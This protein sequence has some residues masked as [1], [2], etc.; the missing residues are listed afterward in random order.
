MELEDKIDVST[1]NTVFRDAIELCQHLGIDF[2]WIDRLCIVQDDPADL[3]REIANMG[4]IYE[5]ALLNIGGVA[6]ASQSA[7]AD[8]GLFTDRSDYARANDPMCARV[9]RNNYDQLCWIYQKSV[10]TSLN[11]SAM[12]LRG[13]ILQERLLSPRSIYF[14][15]QL[16]WECSELMACEYFPEGVPRQVQQRLV[17][18]PQ[19][20][21]VDYPLKI[22][23]LI[24]DARSVAEQLLETPVELATHWTSPYQAW[25]KVI[26]RYSRCYLT[27]ESDCLLALSGLAK[28]FA[29]E[30]DDEYLAGL[31]RK[32]LLEELLWYCDKPPSL[33]DSEKYLRN[34]NTPSWSW[35][36]RRPSGIKFISDEFYG[37]L[38]RFSRTAKLEEVT[39]ILNG[40]DPTGN[41]SSGEIRICGPLRK[42]LGQIR[43]KYTEGPLYHCE[44]WD[45]GYYRSGYR[46]VSNN[47]HFLM[48]YIPYNDIAKTDDLDDRRILP[49]YEGRRVGLI[50]ESV[51]SETDVYRRVG[52][53][54]HV[55]HT[56]KGNDDY[57][58]PRPGDCEEFKDFDPNNY[59]RQTI[60]II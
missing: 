28:H 2:L 27:H 23:T 24:L 51:N 44:W 38:A 42:T 60:T 49:P 56:W 15:H 53:F 5:D 14:D 20:W 32:D 58:K 16:H 18:Y 6:A 40:D 47:Y 46:V 11:E 26:E 17:G 13:W 22:T 54:M 9:W 55:C 37:V 33:L 19:R 7:R 12:M 25:M 43:E 35:A 45:D 30:F 4:Y 1:L 3:A 36:S 34:C 29:R 59:E 50:L 10:Y 31:W 57:L 48:G 21:G 8:E 39:V 41:V 52:V